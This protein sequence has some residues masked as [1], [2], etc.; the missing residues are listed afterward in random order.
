VIFP[1]ANNAVTLK[2]RVA[3]NDGNGKA[4]AQLTQ[5]F[6]IV[7]NGNDE[8][9]GC[10]DKTVTTYEKTSNKKLAFTKDF[11]ATNEWEQAK[12]E[13][14]QAMLI[15]PASTALMANCSVSYK[16]R[17]D[18]GSGTYVDPKALA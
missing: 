4:I 2:A 1:V 9:T 17:V 7:I 3:F 6:E 11:A 14:S 15:D 12:L 13:I 8:D 5:E 18:D 10:T 16:I